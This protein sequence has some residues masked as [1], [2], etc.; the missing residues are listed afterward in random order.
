MSNLS[1]DIT[2]ERHAYSCGN[3]KNLSRHGIIYTLAYLQTINPNLSDIG[4]MQTKQMKR[5]HGDK[6]SK[7]LSSYLNKIEVV[8]CSNL[9][10]TMETAYLTYPNAKKIY[11][12]P[13]VNEKFNRFLMALGLDLENAQQNREITL[14]RM[15]ELGYDIRKFDFSLITEITGDKLVG[16]NI[17]LF[18][19]KVVHDRW[20]NP[21]SRFYLGKNGVKR[22]KVSVTTHSEWMVELLHLVRNK[23]QFYYDEPIYKPEHC[24]EIV[25]PSVY[26]TRKVGN[27]S[28]TEITV[29]DR[30]VINFLKGNTALPPA[31]RVY[32]TEA[33]FDEAR[34]K[35]ILLTDKKRIAKGQGHNSHVKRCPSNIRDMEM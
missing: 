3:A 35:C 29:R 2:F 13:Y 23:D 17:E 15:K 12:L 32:E 31:T 4:V 11:V 18:L 26:Q 9:M 10:R 19:E 6:K 25:S 20:L 8:C 34:N 21:E 28:L 5:A 27:C 22:V 30:D 14:E 7:K 24:R 1:L 16:P 33:I